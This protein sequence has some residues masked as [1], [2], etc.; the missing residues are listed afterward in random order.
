M[1]CSV[2]HRDDSVRTLTQTVNRL[3]VLLTQL[4]PGGAPRQLTADKAAQ[5]LRTVRPRTAGPRTLRRLA[6]D[7]IA[8]IRH[9]DRRITATTTEISTELAASATTLTE[10]RGIAGLTAGKILAQVGDVNR[11][12]SVTA[13]AS[14]SG[15]APIEVDPPARGMS[16]SLLIGGL[17]QGQRQSPA[18]STPIPVRW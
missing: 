5:L 1:H 13:F 7:L 6:A 3:R 17:W 16:G 10:L 11:F 14:Y 9:L 4:L 18:R 8:G 15:T 2:E 12:R